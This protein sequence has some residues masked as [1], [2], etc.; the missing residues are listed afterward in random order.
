MKEVDEEGGL[1]A[2]VRAAMLHVV[3][4]SL[5][6]VDG[7]LSDALVMIG[8]DITSVPLDQPLSC[9]EDDISPG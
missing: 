6:L 2:L 5:G 1:H 8:L 9:L 7:A 4:G 3:L